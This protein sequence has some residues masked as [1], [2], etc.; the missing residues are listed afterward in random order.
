MKLH[1]VIVGFHVISR[2]VDFIRLGL[3]ILWTQLDQTF[4]LNPEKSFICSYD[5]S[6]GHPFGTYFLTIASSKL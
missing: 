2:N 4:F 5:V 6:L 3:S 1:E